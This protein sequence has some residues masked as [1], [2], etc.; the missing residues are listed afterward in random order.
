MSFLFTSALYEIVKTFIDLFFFVCW[1]V[2]FLFLLVLYEKFFL[3]PL[4]ILIDNF[5]SDL[6]IFSRAP[7]CAAEEISGD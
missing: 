3:I 1:E 7:L 4:P 2:L 5:S 6:F